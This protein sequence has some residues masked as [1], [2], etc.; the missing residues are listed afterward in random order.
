MRIMIIKNELPEWTNLKKEL[1]DIGHQVDVGEHPPE[2]IPEVSAGYQAVIF[3]AKGLSSEALDSMLQELGLERIA[4]C[5]ADARAA[6]SYR[7]VHSVGNAVILRRPLE[8]SSLTAALTVSPPHSEKENTRGDLIKVLTAMG[9]PRGKTG[10]DTLCDTML[11][12]LKKDNAGINLKRD[13]YPEAGRLNGQSPA[14]VEKSL[15]RLSRAVWVNASEK[16]TELVLG[17]GAMRE[18]K[19]P[20]LKEILASMALY[21]QSRPSAELLDEIAACDD[22]SRS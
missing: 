2:E 6:S 10:F 22:T 8:L 18:G 20:P 1:N 9:Y 3:A 5:V 12:I 14:A 19:A 17:P 11:L 21:F 16:L 4:V 7:P 13:I 15:E